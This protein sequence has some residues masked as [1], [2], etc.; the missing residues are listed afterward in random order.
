MDVKQISIQTKYAL[1]EVEILLQKRKQM[2]IKIQLKYSVYIGKKVY[3]ILFLGHSFLT[4]GN[5]NTCTAC[6][7][8]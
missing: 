8:H 5:L 4:S 6:I 1:K 7:G 2:L 3:L